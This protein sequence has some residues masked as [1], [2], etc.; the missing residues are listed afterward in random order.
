MTEEPLASPPVSAPQVGEPAAWRYRFRGHPGRGWSVADGLP[1]TDA[2]EYEY[3]PLFTVAQ[4]EAR[5][6]EV[7]RER[8]KWMAEAE[9]R[10]NS[11]SLVMRERDEARAENERVR[12]ERDA[13]IETAVAEGFEEGRE[14]GLSEAKGTTVK[15]W[16]AMSRWLVDHGA[17]DDDEG[18]GRSVDDMMSALSTFVDER[19]EAAERKLDDARKVIEPVVNCLRRISTTLVDGYTI[20][21]TREDLRALRLFL[22]ET[23]PDEANNAEASP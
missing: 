13:E 6:S 15:F 19:A 21:I 2:P 16:R 9:D 14:E 11:C 17:M 3:E 18:E 4:V 8:D 20:E 12:V 23:A 10:A 5:L 1:R 22:V 7:T